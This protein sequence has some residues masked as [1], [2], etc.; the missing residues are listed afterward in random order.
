VVNF[1]EYQTHTTQG[2]IEGI[3]IASL[4]DGNAIV[5]LVYRLRF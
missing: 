2:R 1:L 5:K 3:K 4:V